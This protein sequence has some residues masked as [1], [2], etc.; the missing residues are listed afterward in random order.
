MPDPLIDV[1]ALSDSLHQLQVFDVR[2]YLADPGRGESEYRAAHIPGAVFVDLDKDLS[3]VPGSNGR[4]PLPTPG[5]FALTLGRLGLHRNDQVVVYDDAA[6]RIA[7]RLWWML[8]S[9]GHTGVRVLDGGIPA[10]IEAGNTTESGWIAPSHVDY[11]TVDDFSNSV[12][13]DELEGRSL[14][15]ARAPERFRGDFEPVD[16]RPGH[17]PGAINI[18]TDVFVEDGRLRSADSMASLF[19]GIDDPVMS[20]GS[21]VTACHA[22][23]AYTIAG[24]PIPD[25]YVGSYSE[26]SRT[27]RDVS[28]GET[29]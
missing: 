11:G 18:P 13:L 10:W 20:C 21:G 17:I 19:V 4:H 3:S 29:P 15:D 8:R 27:D 14:V 24:N 7:A 5:D 2:W 16:P 28:T 23:L 12:T 1:D 9:I 22:A 6:G 26:W 25:V